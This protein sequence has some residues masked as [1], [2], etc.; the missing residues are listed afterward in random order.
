MTYRAGRTARRGPAGAPLLGTG[1]TG[2]WLN[3]Y[4]VLQ[5]DIPLSSQIEHILRLLARERLG[6]LRA[7]HHG[8]LE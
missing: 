3:G 8:Q 5:G 7:C 4:L 1:L 6:A 2:T